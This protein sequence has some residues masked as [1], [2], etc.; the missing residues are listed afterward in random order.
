M[1]HLY[2][3]EIFDRA[4]RYKDMALSSELEIQ[5]D[6][7]TLENTSIKLPMLAANK[8]DFVHITDFWGRVVHQG[9]ILDTASGG[10]MSTLK[11]APL[12]SLLDVQ[13]QYDRSIFDLLP[14]E[15]CIAQIIRDTYIQNKDSLQNI[16]GLTVEVKTSTEGTKL[17]IR[18][19]IHA[20][21]DIIT[22]ALTLHDIVVQAQLMPQE[23]AL[24]I[25][26]G[27]IE[28]MSVLEADLGNCLSQNFVLTD[29]YGTLNKMT[30]VNKDKPSETATYYLHPDGSINQSNTDR[31]I[32]VFFWAEYVQGAENFAKEAYSRAYEQM[33]PEKYQQCIELSFREGDKMVEPGALGIGHKVEIHHNNRIFL[34]V[35]TGYR[36][37]G[38]IVTLT[39]GCI[40]LELT[41]KLIL[42]RRAE[43]K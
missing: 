26:V 22:K 15:N 40:R 18:S 28:E 21:W 37:S 11:V 29:E 13:V 36:Q 35:L 2:K 24:H 39:F 6:Y 27:R 8:G 12:L 43:G 31:I 23:K 4:Y 19:N 38:G 30:F 3:T 41:K 34:S 7:L 25:T 32:P 42:A 9:I 10:G 1:Q 14:L 33:A 20:F 16:K 5:S 17:D